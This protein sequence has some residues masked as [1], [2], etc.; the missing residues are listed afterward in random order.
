M[1]ATLPHVLPPPR[2]MRTLSGAFDLNT[3]PAIRIDPKARDGVPELARELA[4]KLATPDGLTPEVTR[5]SRAR[6]G[7]LLLQLKPMPSPEHHRLEIKPGDAVLTGGGPAGLFYAAQTLLQIAAQADHGHIPALRIEDGPD[8]RVRGFYHDVS[9]GKV[10][11][12]ETLFALVERLAHYKINQLQLYIEHTYAFAAHPDI[13]AGSDPLTAEDIRA[14]DAHAARHHI[15]LVPSLST[16]G[17]FYPA[18]TSPRKHHLNELAID[19]SQ[20]PF[21]WWDRIGHYTLDC[22]NPAS[23]ELVREMILELRPLFRSRFFNICCDETFDLGKGRNAAIA[24]QQGNGRLYIDFLG[25]LM[26]VVREAGCTPMFW[27]DI[28]GNHPELAGEVP[29]DAVALDWDYSADLKETKAALFR[30]AGIPFYICP[31]VCGWDRWVHDLDTAT[32][33]IVSFARHGRR[34][35]AIG[36]LNTD[37]GDRGH[38]NALGNSMHG[39][40]L[41]AAAAWNARATDAAPFD[42]AFARIH[43]SDTSGRTV[44]LMREAGRLNL[45]SWRALT[46][47]IDPTPHRP[48]EWWDAATGVPMELLAVDPRRAFAAASK[49]ERI[50]GQFKKLTERSRPSDDLARREWLFGC[51]MQAAMNRLGGW[52]ACLAAKRKPAGR[53]PSAL[54]VADSTRVMEREFSELWHARNKPSEY[55]RLR[56]ALL[57][58]A[59]RLELVALRGVW[60]RMPRPPPPP[61]V[62]CDPRPD[63]PAA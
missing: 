50:A 32:A 54:A 33:N 5:T 55:W 38:I 13:W 28:V 3:C 37:W 27:G 63:P 56:V 24:Q 60:V 23:L 7:E 29:R 21:S 15:E 30:R 49:L 26:Q 22:R 59:R 19:A 41:G 61:A 6:P 43:W 14:L 57:E 48:A 31:G 25:K 4:R 52:I 34:H 16:F 11:T 20:L 40:V 45:V 17:H 51:R 46:L 1:P 47:W 39:L 58:F 10:P 8:Y 35:G 62:D 36:L 12:R 53:M 42:A 44:A 9:R 2:R 18:L